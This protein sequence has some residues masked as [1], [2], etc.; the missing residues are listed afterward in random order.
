MRRYLRVLLVCMIFAFFSVLYV[1]SQLASSLETSSGAAGSAARP[2]AV[3][4]PRDP[5]HRA[6]KG[7][8][9]EGPENQHWYNRCKNLSV[10]YWNPYW[11]LPPGV[12]GLNCFMD[13]AFRY[14]MRRRD[15]TEGVVVRE[16]RVHLAVVSCGQ[17]LN[18]T[19]TMLKSAVLFGQRPLTFHIFAEDQL[20]QGF[21]AALEAWPEPFRSRFNFTIYPISF[22]REN[23]AEWKRLFKPCASQRLFLPILLKDVDSLLYVDTDILFLRPVEDVWAFL[24]RFNSSQMAAM[25]PEHEDPRIA[26]Y[27][28]FARHPYHGR[29][30]LNSGVMLM[31]MSRMRAKLFKNDMTSVSLSWE[32]LLMPL[33]Q[34]YKLNITWGDQDLLNIIFHHNP[35]SLFVFPCQWNFRPDHCIYGSNCAPAEEEGV[36]ILHGNRGVYHDEKQPAFRA[37]YDAINQ[38]VFGAD[39]LQTLLFPLEE[40]LQGTTHTYC[41]RARHLLTKRLQLSVQSLRARGPGTPARR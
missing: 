8:G 4:Q 3:Y 11:R 39:P 21:R 6:R 29:T 13:S 1:F 10:T 19:L 33:L 37:M 38:Y 31:N 12:C 18:E 5:G 35:E 34:K 15:V 24:S 26:W 20:H 25:A 40:R 41:G 16:E 2:R 7:P 9:N 32:D 27:S 30:G 23:A 14:I 22:P 36:F 28:R 17:R